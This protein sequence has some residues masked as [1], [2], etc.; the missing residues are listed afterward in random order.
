PLVCVVLEK[1][2]EEGEGGVGRDHG[3]SGL[4]GLEAT[5]QGRRIDESLERSVGRRQD[6]L[7]QELH[8]RLRK[9]A[10]LPRTAL[11][12]DVGNSSVAQHRT[13]FSTVGRA[14]RT[15]DAKGSSPHEDTSPFW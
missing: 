14:R 11:D 8:P 2:I 9:T 10:C 5:N 13:Q 1:S 7:G 12:P 15:D 6:E 4:Q 3:A